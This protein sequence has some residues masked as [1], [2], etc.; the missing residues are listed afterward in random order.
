MK[1]K[2]VLFDAD[3]TLWDFSKSARHALAKTIGHFKIKISPDYYD[4][5]MGINKLVWDAY[6]RHEIT[7]AELR[8]IRFEKFLDALGE[9][10]DPEEMSSYYLLELSKTEFLIKG[11]LPL[12]EQLKRDGQQ[13]CLITNG[14]KDVQRPRIENTG[15]EKYFETIVISDEIGVAKPNA[16]FFEYAFSE[17]GKPEKEEVIVIGDSL[18]S[19]IK[20]GNGFGLDTCWFNPK[21]NANLS[22]IQPTFE[23]DNLEATKPILYL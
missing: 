11:A 5:Y 18:K 21:K 7:S 12:L 3:D 23:I 14:L 19:D 6:E 9:Y 22:K 1:Y 20:G 2:W 16:S 10:R 15:F 4:V 13:L 17:I 8:T